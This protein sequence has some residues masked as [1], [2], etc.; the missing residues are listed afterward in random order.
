MEHVDAEDE[1]ITVVYVQIP[2]GKVV[3]PVQSPASDVLVGRLP[4]PFTPMLQVIQGGDHAEDENAAF[5]GI[6][7]DALLTVSAGYRGAGR[8][9]GNPLY[10][11]VGQRGERPS[12]MFTSVD[13]R[14]REPTFERSHQAADRTAIRNLFRGRD[15]ETK[16]GLHPIGP[17]DEAPPHTAIVHGI[18]LPA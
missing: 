4:S 2:E 16:E 14:M 3:G 1:T 5:V 12:P 8:V 9:S 6:E 11:S 10:A 7:G 15:Q 18:F 13:V 17:P